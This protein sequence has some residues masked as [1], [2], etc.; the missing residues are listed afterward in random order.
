MF[1][2]KWAPG[3]FRP[4]F[5]LGLE[6]SARDTFWIASYGQRGHLTTTFPDQVSRRLGCR[7]DARATARDYGRGAARPPAAAVSRTAEASIPI[8]RAGGRS[9]GRGRADHTVRRNARG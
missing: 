5:S 7:M 8:A 4:P 9:R 1:S 2:E 6:P 3:L